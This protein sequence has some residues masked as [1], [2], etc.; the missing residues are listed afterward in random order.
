MKRFIS[1]HS[2]LFTYGLFLSTPLLSA[3][4]DVLFYTYFRDNG[5]DGT[6]LAVSEDGLKFTALNGD[7]PLLLPAKW[8]GQNLTRD[9]SMVYHDGLFHAVWTSGW[10]GTIFA[11]AE[12]KDLVHWSDPV[13]VQVAS[14]KNGLRPRQTWAPEI[15]W[16]PIQSNYLVTVNCSGTIN[17][18]GP[19]ASQIRRITEPPA[20]FN[21]YA[22][23]TKDG[24]DFSEAGLW[25]TQPFSVIDA[26]M[27]YDA[28]G[29]AGTRGRWIM[30]YKNESNPDRGGKNLRFSFAPA[31]FSQ[32]WTD[33]SQP[34]AGPGS[35][36]R[37]QELAE[38]PC[39]I[40][41]QNQWLLYWD[42]FADGHY[43]MAS[44]TDLVHWT[45]RTSELSLPPH[46]RHGTVFRVPRS[47]LETVQKA[48]A[49]TGTAEATVLGPVRDVREAELHLKRVRI[50]G[51]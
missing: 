30:V 3:Q 15:H 38:G 4:N 39:L 44:S 11:Y 42:A 29:G 37:S 8:P 36:I 45:D 31:D 10:T 41:W 19:I 21:V 7:K 14:E 9:T 50:Y 17:P 1:L 16:D 12:S 18:Q 25:F 34:V 46:P 13:K 6:C 26:Q 48:I 22:T 51:S 20:E 49:A 32:P 27:C 47:V 33:A 23:R 2:L 43:S 35:T 40:R 28:E 24:I 5:Q